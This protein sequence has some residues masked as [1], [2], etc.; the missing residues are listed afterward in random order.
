MILD[1]PDE[2]VKGFVKGLR[3]KIGRKFQDVIG[4]REFPSNR[5]R[6]QVVYTRSQMKTLCPKESVRDVVY[7]EVSRL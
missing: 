1:K 3:K 4:E 7:F 5:T 2:T 6:Y